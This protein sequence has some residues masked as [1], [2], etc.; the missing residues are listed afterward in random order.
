MPPTVTTRPRARG[1]RAGSPTGDPA[2]D[3][4][5][6]QQFL[7]EGRSGDWETAT[8]LRARCAALALALLADGA[9]AALLAAGWPGGAENPGRTTS[10][11][12]GPWVRCMGAFRQHFGAVRT[13]RAAQS[14]A[15][16]A[17]LQ[18]ALAAAL[19]DKPVPVRCADGTLLHAYPKS[20]VALE[21]LDAL[22]GGVGVLQLVQGLEETTTAGEAVVVAMG[23]P[24]LRSDLAK[25]WY[26]IATDPSG[27]LPFR[28]EDFAQDRV[29]VPAEVEASFAA[30]LPSDL[31]ALV[32]GSQAANRHRAEQLV[33][34]FPRQKGAA[35]SRLAFSTYLGA[36]I[37]AKNPDAWQVLHEWPLT[38]VLAITL[39]EALTADETRRQAEAEA[40]AKQGGAGAGSGGRGPRVQGAG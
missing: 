5:F 14:S 25:L 15:A 30:R 7:A 10:R 32:V 39:S 34:A 26:W 36:F 35:P 33:A 22:D 23:V 28:R 19:A 8:G 3:R 37:G 4:V 9:D 24:I 11:K 17:Q 1:A 21:F 16:A 2:R 31:A 6:Y 12:L 13:G 20:Y 18:E 40:T 27:A 29:Q 38:R